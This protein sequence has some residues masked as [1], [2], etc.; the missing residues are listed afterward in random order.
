M[1]TIDT[2]TSAAYS[3]L[4]ADETLTGMCTAY[5]GERRPATAEN[6]SLTVAAA[7]LEP[8]GGDGMWLCDIVITG[9]AGLLGDGASDHAALEDITAR[10][11]L[12]LAD[13]ELV[14]PGAKAFPLIEGETS[15]P[16][17]DR[18]HSG[19]SSMES[20]FGLVFLRY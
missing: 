4:A 19:E 12:L 18:T 13:I 8:G 1:P 15:G 20:T 10:V 7:R 6:P 11:K 14:L 5:K 17:W 3:L 16:D 2:I 9:Y